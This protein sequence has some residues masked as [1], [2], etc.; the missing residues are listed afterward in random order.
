MLIQDHFLILSSS[1]WL[2][3]KD[4]SSLKRHEIE[5]FLADEAKKRNSDLRE[6][7]R[8]A[9]DSNDWLANNEKRRQTA[10]QQELEAQEQVDQ[11]VSESEDA[12]DTRKGKGLKKRKRDS[13]EELSRDKKTTKSRKDGAESKKKTPGGKSRKNG[14]S[15]SVV[16]SEDDGE[17]AD[18]D[19]V[20]PSKKDSTPPQKKAK[21][22]KDDDGDD[23]KQFYLHAVSVF[24]RGT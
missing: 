22:D 10:A 4:L 5:A 21:R 20:G 2:H 7:Y 8:I 11:L 17:H 6:G 16:E 9:L 3:P 14:K 23:C 1:S 13:E 12:G 24:I 19:D 15:K 18:D